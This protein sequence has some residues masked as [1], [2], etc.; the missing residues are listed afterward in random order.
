MVFDV[1]AAG[2]DVLAHEDAEE[3]FRFARRV[4]GDPQQGAVLGVHGG[5]PQ[6][7]GVHLAQAF[8]AFDF[9]P[10]A[11]A[12]KNGVGHFAQA[13]HR[14]DAFAGGGPRRTARG[15]GQ[16]ELGWGLSPGDGLAVF[17]EPVVDVQ[18]RVLELAE[19]RFQ[20]HH[21]VHLAAYRDPARGHGLSVG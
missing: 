7:V 15:R 6:L 2:F 14:V 10:A 5:V 17:D 18:A 12:F 8:E 21:L 3:V 19:R 16:F 11:A 13:D 20:V 1:L 4:P 9:E